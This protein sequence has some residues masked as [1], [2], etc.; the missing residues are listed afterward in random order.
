MTALP[1]GRLNIKNNEKEADMYIYINKQTNKQ[2]H[3]HKNGKHFQ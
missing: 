3:T 1:I 2:K